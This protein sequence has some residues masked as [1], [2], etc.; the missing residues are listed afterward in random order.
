[1]PGF[2]VHSP[3]C[4]FHGKRISKNTRT[5]AA[6]NPENAFLSH[7]AEMCRARAVG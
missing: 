2:R 5:N 6:N 4:G 3:A 7:V 1:M